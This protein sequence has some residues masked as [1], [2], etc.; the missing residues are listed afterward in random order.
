MGSTLGPGGVE[1]TSPFT[2]SR[3]S[4][5]VRRVASSG[6]ASSSASTTPAAPSYSV[7]GNGG[8][9]ASIA[10]AFVRN[11]LD[12]HVATY[13]RANLTPEPFGERRRAPRE[14]FETFFRT[15]VR[16]DAEV[17]NELAK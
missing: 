8:S 10:D 6:A 12:P 7:P 13:A 4:R 1:A 15:L 17:D 5:W 16:L 9:P 3:P 11:D 14:P 2:T